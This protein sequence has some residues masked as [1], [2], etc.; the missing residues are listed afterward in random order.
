MEEEK[1]QPAEKTGNPGHLLPAKI[2]LSTPVKL[3]LIQN[4]LGNMIVLDNLGRKQV[5]TEVV[6]AQRNQTMYGYKKSSYVTITLLNLWCL[7]RAYENLA[8]SARSLW[9][10]LIQAAQGIQQN[11]TFHLTF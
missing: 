2:I 11:N 7:G 4:K 9:N 3:S 8:E 5:S 1:K 10:L 6:W